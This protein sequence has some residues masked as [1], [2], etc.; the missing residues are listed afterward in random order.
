MWRG[1]VIPVKVS[2]EKGARSI[3]EQVQDQL[4]PISSIVPKMDLLLS[5]F[6]LRLEL[7]SPICQG[8]DLILDLLEM[9]LWII[10][11]DLGK[12]FW[13]YSSI[14]RGDNPTHS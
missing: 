14:S 13:K 5:C 4:G 12:K 2:W 9:Y 10:P 8:F 1:S 3:C 7:M 11:K 6:G